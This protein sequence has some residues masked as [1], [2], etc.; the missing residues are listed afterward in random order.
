M[1]YKPQHCWIILM[2]HGSAGHGCVRSK[3]GLRVGSRKGCS[4]SLQ[5]R[6]KMQK[7]AS[8]LKVLRREG[9]KEEDRSD[10]LLSKEYRQQKAEARYTH[11]QA[12]P[13]CNRRTSKARRLQHISMV[14]LL[15]QLS[16]AWKLHSTRDRDRVKINRLWGVNLDNLAG[17]RFQRHGLGRS[18]YL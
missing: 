10:E 18:P 11:Q 9:R 16:V 7:R 3:E 12:S 13:R 4:P 8:Y 2:G 15:N 6:S 17:S 5:G 1:L 14:V